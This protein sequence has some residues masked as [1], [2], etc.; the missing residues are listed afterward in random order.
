MTAFGIPC[1]CECPACLP[2]TSPSQFQATTAGVTAVECPSCTDFNAMQLL[3]HQADYGTLPAAHLITDPA[4]GARGCLWQATDEIDCQ[5]AECDTCGCA[6]D[7]PSPCD[8][9]LDECPNQCSI[10]ENGCE[11]CEELGC[12]YECDSDVWRPGCLC[13]SGSCECDPCEAACLLACPAVT[14]TVQAWLYKDEDNHVVLFVLGV[15]TDRHGNQFAVRGEHNFGA[16][17][18]DCAAIDQTVSV[19]EYESGV[20]YLPWALDPVYAPCSAPTSI[21]IQGI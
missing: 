1:C 6:P 8:E 13:V 9:M 20:T 2:E 21:R 16:V 5:P 10:N 14:W 18:V 12:S 15:L 19:S 4:D 7:C 11:S 3:D 17:Q